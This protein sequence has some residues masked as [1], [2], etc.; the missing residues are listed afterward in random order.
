[1]LIGEVLAHGAVVQTFTG[2]A[3]LERRL[4]RWGAAAVFGVAIRAATAGVGGT[5][6]ALAGSVELTTLGIQLLAEGDVAEDHTD[7][8]GADPAILVEIKNPEDNSH[9]LLE[10]LAVHIEQ[11]LHK[12]VQL[13][14]LVLPLVR[15]N[16]EDPIANHPRQVHEL[17][18]GVLVHRAVL[19][20]LGLRRPECQVVVQDDEIGPKDLFNESL[21]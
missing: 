18:Q 10:G 13:D 8:L 19:S 1:M 4:F 6:G 2:F 12:V 20:P 11:Q 3:R 15:S 9:F 21:V 5:V 14:T 16:R 7:V 17:H